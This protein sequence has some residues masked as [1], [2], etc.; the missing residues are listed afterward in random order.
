MCQT[1]SDEFP[2]SDQ[3][4]FYL[5]LSLTCT[6]APTYYYRLCTNINEVKI[7]EVGILLHCQFLLMENW[8][9]SSGVQTRNSF[10]LTA[11]SKLLG[12]NY[13]KKNAEIHAS[14]YVKNT[15][16]KFY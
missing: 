12:V 14:A 3:S 1:D 8:I 13:V 5:R 6:P 2:A 9:C 16:V 10:L 11:K 15:R 4:R 7:L